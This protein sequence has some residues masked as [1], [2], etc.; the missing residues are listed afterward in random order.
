M[1]TDTA[2]KTFALALRPRPNTALAL[3]QVTLRTALSRPPR[4]PSKRR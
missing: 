3:C 2:G 1:T 4:S